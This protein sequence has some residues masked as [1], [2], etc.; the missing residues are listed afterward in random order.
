MRSGAKLYDIKVYSIAI[1]N[2][3]MAPATNILSTGQQFCY[4]AQGREISCEHSG[5]DAEY[6]TGI[7]IPENRCVVMNDII[8]DSLTGLHW[9]VQAN[10]AEFPLSWQEAFDFVND[11]NDSNFH[12]FND[13]RLPNRRE[14]HSL[15]SYQDTRPAIDRSFSFS[16]IFQS[17]YWSSTTAAI[18][19]RYAWYIDFNGGRLSCGGK[20]QSFMVL[21]VRGNIEKHITKTGQQSCFNQKGDHIDCVGTGQDA[22]IASGIAWPEPRFSRYQDNVIDNLTGLVW[23][24][25]ADTAGQPMDWSGALAVVERLNDDST[26]RTWRLP[27]INELQS[28]V[29]ASKAQPALPDEHPFVSCQDTYWSSTTSVYQPDWAWALYLDKGALGVGQKQQAKFYVWAVSDPGYQD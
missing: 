9:P 13:W 10:V 29:D 18:N 19:K 8:Y 20:D 26:H 6:K 3:L 17:W 11:L 12:N 28:L 14:L 27:N 24:K 1:V 16:E 21:P 23:A 5:Q 22:E 2:I 25:S 4:D 15:I 7:A